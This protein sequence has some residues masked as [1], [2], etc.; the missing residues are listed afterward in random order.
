MRLRHSIIN[1]NDI[2]FL[3]VVLGFCFV[4]HT[5][6]NLNEESHRP[7]WIV[8]LLFVVVELENLLPPRLLF[9]LDSVVQTI[10]FLLQRRYSVFVFKN[11]VV[12]I[13]NLTA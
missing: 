4:F 10:V 1:K 12:V 7:L 5:I 13:C 11:L 2:R 6:N 3:L 9:V 8:A